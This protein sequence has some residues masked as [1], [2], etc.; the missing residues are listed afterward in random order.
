MDAIKEYYEVYVRADNATDP[1]RFTEVEVC[2]S[3]I[4]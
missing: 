2:Q 3:Q 4:L 1:L